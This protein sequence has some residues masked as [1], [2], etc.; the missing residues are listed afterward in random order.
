MTPDQMAE[1]AARLRDVAKWDRV[2]RHNPKRAAD[3]DAAA[4]LIE[5]MAQREP[6]T[7]EQIDKAL[8]TD[9]HAIL[10]LADVGSLTTATFKDVL[11]RLARTIEKAHGIWSEK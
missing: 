6:L 10:L 7:D 2:M 4:D 5:S 3:C 9:P 11:R 8:Q 1:L